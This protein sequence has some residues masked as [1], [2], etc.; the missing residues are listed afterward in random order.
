GLLRAFHRRAVR[1]R[2]AFERQRGFASVLRRNLVFH[3]VGDLR[4]DK[5]ARREVRFAGEALLLGHLQAAGR[6]QRHS[7]F[8]GRPFFPV[9]RDGR[10]VRVDAGSRRFTGAGVLRAAFAGRQ[11]G[12]H[13]AFHRRA[14]CVDGVFEFQRRCAGVVDDDLVFHRARDLR[15][16]QFGGREVF[17]AR[18]ALLLDHFEAALLLEFRD[19]FVGG[20]VIA[21]GGDGGDVRVGARF[22]QL[23]RTRVLGRFFAG[24]QFGLRW[25]ARRRAVRVR[26]VFEFQR[27]LARVLDDD[28]VFHRRRRFARQLARRERRFAREALL[29]DYFEGL[30][31]FQ[32][33]DHFVGGL[34]LAA[35]GDRR[36][37]RV[38]AGFRQ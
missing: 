31:R 5:F 27:G 20:D 12:L 1:V 17:F 18:E 15:R 32:L 8:V 10:H 29:L 19:D 24:R 2:D 38:G 6:F 34:F 35:G 37:V 14:H 22:R 7:Y 9:A 21:A 26:D 3:R 28:L 30:R 25:A 23:E 36:D 16:R 4:R 13:R 33:D 11:F